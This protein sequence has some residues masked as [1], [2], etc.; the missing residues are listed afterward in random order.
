MKLYT[1]TGSMS[2]EQE[3]LVW[4]YFWSVVALVFLALQI[5]TY[6]KIRNLKNK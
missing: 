3:S 5:I 6:I 4:I 1:E 2:L